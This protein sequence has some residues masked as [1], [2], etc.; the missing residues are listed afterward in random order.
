[1]ARRDQ[2][3]CG[4]SMPIV[5]LRLKIRPVRPVNARAFVPIQSEPVQPVEDAGHHLGRR[6]LGVGILDAQYEHAAVATGV[7]PVEEGGTCASNVEVAGGRW[8]KSHSD[9]HD[10]I[11]YR[12]SCCPLC[13][14]VVRRSR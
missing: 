9:G 13:Q 14:A 1:M 12:R 8:G 10:T 3:R 6:S 11:G 2:R 7:E 5:A 4:R